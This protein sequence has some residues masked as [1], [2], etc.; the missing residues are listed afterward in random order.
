MSYDL[1][2]GDTGSK[3]VVT[4]ADNDTGAAV[5]L[6]GST[7]RFR[8]EGNASMVTR[9]ATVTNSAGGVAEYQFAA[10]E[11]IAPKMKIEVEVTDGIGQVVTS[12]DLIEL[13]VR[14]E[15]G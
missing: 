6:A 11:I 12:T 5:D 9:T 7:V 4:V 14:E 15:L 1:V 8:W 2:T 10:G 3:L 13:T